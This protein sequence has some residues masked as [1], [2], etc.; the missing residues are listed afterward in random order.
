MSESGHH[1]ESLAVL[2]LSFERHPGNIVLIELPYS[3]NGKNSSLRHIGFFHLMREGYIVV[4]IAIGQCPEAES[5]IVWHRV[6]SL[7]C[8]P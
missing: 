1:R 4:A 6:P 7:V 2:P 8:R 3:S 5:R